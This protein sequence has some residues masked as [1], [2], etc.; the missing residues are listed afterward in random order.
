[1][2]AADYSAGE[3]G[4]T[5]SAAQHAYAEAAN[6]GA[7][8]PPYLLRDWLKNDPGSGSFDAVL[9]I[10]STEHMPDLGAFCSEA[11][12][13]LRPGGRLVV[14]AWLTRD[15]LNRW[16]RRHLIEGICREGRFRSMGTADDYERC[17]RA[18]GLETVKRQDLS[19]W[20]KRTSPVCVGRVARGAVR[21]PSDLRFLLTEGSGHKV[22][23]LTLFRFWLAY[24]LRA[25]R[26][27]VLTF[28]KPPRPRRAGRAHATRR[29]SFK[30]PGDA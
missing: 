7:P 27:G 17:A 20:V 19:G 16:E 11:A 22:L 1:V 28:R 5:I 6:P 30:R 15:R 26:Y 14:C 21:D 25:M 9:A 2:L 23:V 24:D 4:L 29:P 10:E 8:N 13:V 3:T 12:R 18:S